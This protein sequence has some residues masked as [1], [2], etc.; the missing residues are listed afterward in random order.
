M[1]SPSSL[2]H[3]R[4]L[5]VGTDFRDVFAETLAALYRF[6]AKETEFFPGYKNPLK[7]PLRFLGPA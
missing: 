5:P 2:Y 4:D 1:A 6:D 3:K 7:R